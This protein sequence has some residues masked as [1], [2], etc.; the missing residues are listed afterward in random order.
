MKSI[1]QMIKIEDV[2]DKVLQLRNENVIIDS[3]VATLYGVETK[4]INEA[5]K[6][7]P[8]KFPEGYVFKL[9]QQEKTEVVENFD[10]LNQLKFS[11]VEPRAFTERGLYMLATILKGEQAVQT[12]LLI[13]ETFVKIRELSRTIAA[14][15]QTED[16]TVQKSLMQKGGELIS[17][18]LGNDLNTTES[19]TELELNFAMLKLKHKVVR[20]K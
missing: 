9:T 17:D 20:K 13:I 7:N 11:K 4:R 5:V 15:P 8:E 16:K 12:T 19:E 10:H 14:L 3:D 18:I 2:Q 6:N 1:M